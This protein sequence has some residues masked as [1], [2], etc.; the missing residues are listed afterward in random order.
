MN[1]TAADRASPP[2]RILDLHGGCNFRD[3]GG[4][5]TE[6]GRLVRWG[7]VYR[8]G[9]LSYFTDKDHEAL[10]ALGVHSICDLRRTEER[11]R[12]PTRWPDSATRPLSWDDG[13]AV[14]TIREL[15][16]AR[17]PTAAGMFDAMIDLYRALPAWIGPRIGGMFACI[18][19]DRVPIVVHCAAGKDRT[20]IAVAVLLRALGV[21]RETVLEDYLL[22]ND[23]GDFEQFI[24]TRHRARLGLADP[25]HPLPLMPADVRRVLF[26][27]HE[28]FLEAAFDQIDAQLGGLDAYLERAAGV[29]ASSRDRVLRVMLD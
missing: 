20:G 10:R 28:R 11:E 5:R 27:A 26:S 9:V 29:D 6:D 19:Q 14:P 2:A 1:Q 3:V 15:A 17:P 23:A 18:A 24:R 12:E 22:T 8:A 21:P 7:R 13:T 25:E 16:A 4:Y